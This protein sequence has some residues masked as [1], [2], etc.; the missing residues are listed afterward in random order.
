MLR[1]PFLTGGGA[2]ADI[3]A[4]RFCPRGATFHGFAAAGLTDGPPQP[5][6]QRINSRVAGVDG[7]AVMPQ[8][9]LP[10]LVAGHGHR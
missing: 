8:A 4:A 7:A 2:L 9:S 1:V 5:G 10:G 6:F 3:E